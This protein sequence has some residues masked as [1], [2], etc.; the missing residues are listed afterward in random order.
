VPREAAQAKVVATETLQF[1]TDHGMQIL[2]SAGYTV[3]SDMQRYW[4]DARLYSFGEGTNEI[5]RDLIARE[6]SL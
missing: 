6:L 2:A 3:E 1:V 5:L 4:R